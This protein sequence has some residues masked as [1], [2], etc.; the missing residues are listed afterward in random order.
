MLPFFYGTICNLV[1]MTGAKAAMIC[2]KMHKLGV[3]QKN[4]CTILQADG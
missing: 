1:Q 3:V 2:T 4:I